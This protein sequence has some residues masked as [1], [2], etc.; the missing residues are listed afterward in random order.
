MRGNCGH[1]ETARTT[2]RRSRRGLRAVLLLVTLL[3]QGC[4]LV[5]FSYDHADTLVRWQ[6]DDYVDFDDAQRALYERDFDALWNW[7]RHTQLP[8]YASDLREIADAVASP[9]TA[10]QIDAWIKRAELHRDALIQRCQAPTVAML[11]SLS[12]RQVAQLL[13]ALAHDRHKMAEKLADHS[14][15]Q[16]L[17]KREQDMRDTL[18]T[19]LGDLT[20]AQRMRIRAWALQHQ[21][22]AKLTLEI[23]RAR[24][25]QLAAALADRAQADFSD[26]LGQV[27][28]DQ[29][30]APE[31][32]LDA[33][34]ARNRAAWVSLMVD[35]GHGLTPEQ[36]AHLQRRLRSYARDFTELAAEPGEH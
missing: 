32:K 13:K 4:S 19:W 25:P 36:R 2:G 17:H 18:D 9:V 27:F 14:A 29:G 33:L 16:R 23:Y 12:D 1:P 28:A 11:R 34:Q 6:L 5:K 35:L 10:A 24:A 31:R 26:H 20:Q 3:L 22:T 21:P 30:T 15:E 7:H 8:L